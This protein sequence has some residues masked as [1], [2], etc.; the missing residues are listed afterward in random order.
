M[1]G[2][3]LPSSLTLVLICAALFQPQYLSAEVVPVRH[4]EGLVHGFLVLSTIEGEPLAQ[5]DL[6]QLAKGD[7]VTL[8]LI[9]HFKDGSLHDEATIF[10]QRGTFR[11]LTYHLV[12][13]GPVFE[14]PMDFSL[15]GSTGEVTILSSDHDGKEK[16]ASEHLVLPPDVSNGIV[17]TL[18]KNILS[19]SPR[20]TVSFVAPAPK[21]RLVKLVITPQGQDSFSVAGSTRK[22]THYVVKAEIGGI[23]GLVAP[24]IGKQP[25][26]NHVWVLG[27]EAPAFVKSEGPLY[28]GGPIWRI[29]LAS[30]VWPK[31]SETKP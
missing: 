11:L 18:L 19:V 7:R 6:I 24:L 30:P 28:L 25:S 13:K 9:F 5:G 2:R 10:S 27:G 29:E 31:A 12:Q 14:H 26:D 8:R 21:P 3:V 15:D 17:L 22:A 16:T 1:M 20:T 4:R 23:A